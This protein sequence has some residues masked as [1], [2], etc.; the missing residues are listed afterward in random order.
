[1]LSSSSLLT[2]VEI[3]REVYG[4]T[5]LPKKPVADGAVKLN[6]AA[7]AVGDTAGGGGLGAPSGSG[8][9]LDEEEV[10]ADKATGEACMSSTLARTHTH[11][12][13]HTLVT[14]VDQLST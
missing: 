2:A 12:H 3:A 10:E 1:M 13:T 14:D 7:K 9:L 4:L 5:A 11:A 6:M 8:L